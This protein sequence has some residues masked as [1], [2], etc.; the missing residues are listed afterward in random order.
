M[1]NTLKR[2][3]FKHPLFYKTAYFA[4]NRRNINIWYRYHTINYILHINT[5]KNTYTRI[6]KKDENFALP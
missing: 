5:N 1:K 2:Y 4:Y 6:K 3:D